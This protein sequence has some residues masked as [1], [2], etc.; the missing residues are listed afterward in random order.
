MGFDVSMFRTD[1]PAY[2]EILAVRAERQQ[3]VTDFLDGATE[4]LLAEERDFPWGG[5]DWHPTVGDCVR[6][7]LEEESGAPALHPAGSRS[8]AM[9]HQQA[10]CTASDDRTQAASG[11]GSC[12]VQRRS[13]IRG[14]T[15]GRCSRSI[16]RGGSQE[17]SRSGVIRQ[18]QPRCSN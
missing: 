15:I 18:V 6:V 14:W 4:E 1:P 9:N 17:G 16:Q 2:E 8:A 5:G 7:I 10:R 11:N 12:G 13:R 3:Q